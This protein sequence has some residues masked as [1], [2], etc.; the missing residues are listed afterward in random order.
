MI[1]A[2]SCSSSSQILDSDLHSLNLSID[3]PRED[4]TFYSLTISGFENRK[5]PYFKA[6]LNRLNQYPDDVIEINEGSKSENP[7]LSA[8]INNHPLSL[9]RVVWLFGKEQYRKHAVDF[10]PE[11]SDNGYVV[12]SQMP[13]LLGSMK[14]FQRKVRYPSALEGSG[15]EGRV[16]VMFIVNE[17]GDVEDPEVIEG[18][19]ENI[20]MEAIRVVQEADFKPGMMNGVPIRVQFNMPVFFRDR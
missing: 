5:S 10:T 6:A 18:L 1:F 16:M 9:N 20:D 4:H 14:D 12:I 11:Q 8:K 19:H 13:E 15:I 17:Y 7:Q 3:E 2:L